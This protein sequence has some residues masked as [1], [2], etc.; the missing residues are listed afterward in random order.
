MML[1][2]LILICSVVSAACLAIG[3]TPLG[4][5][6][7]ILVALLTAAS[8]FLA[9]R[10][11]SVCP[12]LVALVIAIGVAGGGLFAHGSSWPVL[13]GTAFALASWDLIRMAHSLV[14]VKAS[15]Q[16]VTRFQNTHYASLGFV[17]GLSLLLTIAGQLVQLQ[18]PLLGILLLIILAIFALDRAWRMLTG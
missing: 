10:R 9:Y 4:G 7:V 5:A 15:A 18:I 1:K 11:P 17:L 14:G 2:L 12:P 16:T 3:Y 13:L 6:I 8:W